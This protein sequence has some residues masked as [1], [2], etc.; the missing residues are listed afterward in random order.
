VLTLFVCFVWSLNMKSIK[1]LSL[2]AVA[3]LLSANAMAFQGEREF[4]EPQAQAAG[5]QLSRAAVQ[6]EAVQAAAAR[7]RAG[8]HD[9]N[10]LSGVGEPQGASALTRQAVREEAIRFSKENKLPFNYNAA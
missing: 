6:A 2:A 4:I 9:G 1:L 10:L 7:A 5:S 3:T 8:E